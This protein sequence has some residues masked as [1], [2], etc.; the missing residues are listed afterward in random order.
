MLF[1]DLEGVIA[2]IDDFL[3]HAKTLENLL[4]LV[5]EVMRPLREANLKLQ[6]EKCF[7]LQ[8]EVTY[9]V[10]II[11]KDGVRPN[12]K[13]LEAVSRTSYT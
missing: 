5:K 9:L 1:R 6:P 12:P 11:S 7:F 13:K 8:T 4:Q 10:H 3:I 2:C